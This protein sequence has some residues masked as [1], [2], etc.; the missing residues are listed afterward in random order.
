MKRYSTLVVFMEGETKWQDNVS[1]AH[2]LLIIKSDSQ[3]LKKKKKF[4]WKR[5]S[6]ILVGE[7]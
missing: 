6:H 3:L 5:N 7:M 1:F 4:K 2:W